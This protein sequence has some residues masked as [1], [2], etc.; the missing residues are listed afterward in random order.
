MSTGDANVLGNPYR[1]R[2]LTSPSVVA[3]SL[4]T[5]A[6]GIWIISISPSAMWSS[7]CKAEN[8]NTPSEVGGGVMCCVYWLL[9]C[10]RY[11]WAMIA[12][13]T[14]SIVAIRVY[15]Q[16]CE[17]GQGDR[18]TT[19][20]ECG[21]GYPEM[22]IKARRSFGKVQYPLQATMSK[23]GIYLRIVCWRFRSTQMRAR[24]SRAC[25]EGNNFVLQQGLPGIA[26]ALTSFVKLWQALAS[27]D[28]L[29]AL[30]VC[31]NTCL[32]VW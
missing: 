13:C 8:V 24:V 14:G 27:F 3:G 28:K 1:A 12:C 29:W 21:V 10:W 26:Q 25:A 20:G 17:A 31:P 7:I 32:C 9:L 11:R 5:P 22:Q 30:F 6:A 18:G 2:P 23:V 4:D 15:L 16:W 19:K